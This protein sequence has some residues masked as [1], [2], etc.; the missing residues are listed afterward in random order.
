LSVYLGWEAKAY[1]FF[2]LMNLLMLDEALQ[3]LENPA[4]GWKRLSLW[5]ALS[6]WS[7][8]LSPYF[9]LAMLA[10]AA[11][12]AGLKSPGFKA[13]WKGSWT[14]AL[15]ALPLLP[16]FLKT[17]LLYNG[18]SAYNTALSRA[19]FFS[20]ENFS[21]G[22]WL[23]AGLQLG[24]LILFAVL[25]ALGLK[26]REGLRAP[27]KMLAALAFVPPLLF[28]AVSALGKPNYND[29]AMLISAF[30][31]ILL[32]GLGALSLRGALRPA[33]LAAL[34]LA[35]A[36][37]LAYYA[38]TPAARRV[39]YG[40]V[41][42]KV[43]AQWAEGDVIVHAYFESGLPFQYY[44]ARECAQGARPE[45]RPNVIHQAGLGFS[46]SPAAQGIRGLWRRMNAWLGGHGMGLYAGTDPAFV[47]GETLEAAVKGA[48][49][50]WLV[51]ATDEA[52]RRQMMPIPNGF[53]G[54]QDVGR[55]FD[56]AK[57]TW[58]KGRF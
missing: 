44:A 12:I 31:W 36:A 29:R 49:R 39:D 16:F 41:W 43:A 53:R 50:V 34:L 22:F 56:L 4:R 30:A 6:M 58:L 1:N 18:S 26:A 27:L 19:P 37:S 24:A 28:V 5:V 55:S 9:I 17:L 45:P 25:A 3:V 23:P 46:P 57:E 13:V 7:F 33:A 8:F 40:R 48:K 14:G 42:D 15:W 32:S 51:A 20:L 11:A 35:Q 2:A 47:D 10:G 38:G 52:V 54:G 21:A